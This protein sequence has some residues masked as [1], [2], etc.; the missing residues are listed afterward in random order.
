VPK[1]F[2]PSIHAVYVSSMKKIYIFFL[3]ISCALAASAQNL[4][5]ARA[6]GGSGVDFGQAIAVDNAG[7][8]YSAGLFMN[9]ADFDPGPGVFNLTSAGSWDIYIS[10]L[11]SAGIFQWAKRIGSTGDDRGLSI[12]TDGVA[13]YVTGMF[14]LTVDF[15]P[16]AGT[17][18]LTSAGTVDVF[19]MKLDAS[20][21]FV[22]ANRFGGSG[23]DHGNSIALDAA[24]NVHVS[25]Y[26]T[27]N[28]NGIANLNASGQTDIFIL[29]LTSA[30]SLAW[31]KKFGNSGLDEGNGITVSSSG[32]V[33][34]TG[35]FQV[36]VNFGSSA[37]FSTVGGA[38]WD[39]Y[40]LKLSASG[41]FVWAKQIGSVFEDRG[42]AITTDAAENVYTTGY[43]SDVADFD[44]GPGI[45]NLTGNSN[46]KDAFIQKLDAAGNFIWAKNVGSWLYDQGCSIAVDVTGNVYTAGLFQNTGD[47]DPG[48]GVFNLTSAGMQDI[49]FLKLDASGNFIWALRFGSGINDN[50]YASLTALSGSVYASGFFGQTVDFDPGPGTWNLTSAGA[51]DAFVIKLNEIQILPVELL[52]FTA[53]PVDNNKVKLNWITA[54]EINNDYFTVERSTDANTWESVT[55]VDGNGNTSTTIQYE[56]WDY[57]PYIGISYYRLKQTDFDGQFSYSNTVA[58]NLTGNDNIIIVTNSVTNELVLWSSESGDNSDISIYNSLGEKVFLSHISNLTSHISV[59]TSQLPAG[60]YFVNL[61]TPAGISTG[62]F[63]K[64]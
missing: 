2:F 39:I 52:S 21:N 30:G 48:P 28:A 10:K 3:T 26:F 57:T 47:F 37:N 16:D 42:F 62:K 4:Q 40:I 17:F 32:N 27:G 59:D 41:N 51:N 18:N 7:N 45:Y 55:L 13:V 22:W 54:S 1:F 36:T 24:S 34:S 12:A 61:K 23:D 44:P 53:M 58:V 43:F 20:G 49:F 38:Y 9:T 64:Q 19:I 35:T 8:V 60:I 63:V 5:W 33:Y 6:M 29:K 25:G 14:S 11:D 56:A 46:S 31:S 15:D 50:G